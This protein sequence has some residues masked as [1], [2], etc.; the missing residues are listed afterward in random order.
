[1]LSTAVATTSY[2]TYLPTYLLDD[3]FLC[4]SPRS[5]CNFVTVRRAMQQVSNAIRIGFKPAMLLARVLARR[6]VGG[7]LARAKKSFAPL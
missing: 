7:R 4:S 1:M 5:Y 6:E 2:T 3:W